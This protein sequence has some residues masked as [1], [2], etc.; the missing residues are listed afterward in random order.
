MIPATIEEHLRT[1]HQG[2][3]H[4]H[5]TVAMSAQALA[6]AEHVS[7]HRVA[8][9]VVVRV[10]GRRAM[11]VV[12]AADRV[13]LSVL[14]EATGAPVDLVPE[15]EMT[16]WFSSC[17]IGAEPPFAVFGLPIFVD[18]QLLQE[19]RLVMPAGTYEDA[20]IVDTDEWA[21][22]ERVQEIPNLGTAAA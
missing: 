3:E 7:G 17:E 6:Q 1:H 4:H 14:E 16:T 20:V 13:R 11:A 10:G 15:H 18:A 5:H 8:K 2:Y 19:K 22:C 12:S 21:R 9:P